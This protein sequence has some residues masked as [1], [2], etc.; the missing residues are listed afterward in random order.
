MAP[1]AH[2]PPPCE[3]EP[4]PP[5]SAGAACPHSPDHCRQPAAALL[6]ETF[7]RHLGRAHPA[8]PV[9][10]HSRR[11]GKAARLREAFHPATAPQ[12]LLAPPR[13]SPP[14]SPARQ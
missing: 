4:C 5:A 3:P 13:P 8:L 12:P 7:G 2:R 10:P 1:S 11:H 14:L 9:A 6:R